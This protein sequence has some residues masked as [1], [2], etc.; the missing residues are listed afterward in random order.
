HHKQETGKDIKVIP[1]CAPGAF[2][3]RPDGVIKKQY[4]NCKP[5]DISRT[6]RIDHPGDQSPYLPLKYH[7][8]LQAHH[9]QTRRVE[10]HQDIS[11]YIAD[12]NIECQIR[13]PVPSELPFQLV[14]PVHKNTYLLLHSGRVRKASFWTIPARQ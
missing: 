8:R 14:D 1:E 13:Y 3:R 7:C 5:H 2:Q 6:W 9:I 4:G 12:H 11:Q 10:L